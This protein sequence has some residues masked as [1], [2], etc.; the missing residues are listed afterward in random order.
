MAS[1]RDETF[2]AQ[3]DPSLRAVRGG[4]SNGRLRKVLVAEHD[5]WARSSRQQD[6]VRKTRRLV[7]ESGKQSEIAALLRPPWRTIFP[8]SG[9]AGLNDRGTWLSREL[10]GHAPALGPRRG[11]PQPQRSWTPLPVGL[12]GDGP[13][14]ANEPQTSNR[15]R[16]D[17][18]F[19]RFAARSR[20]PDRGGHPRPR[21]SALRRAMLALYSSS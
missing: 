15:G 7:P 14:V 6:A 17:G 2:S 1:G 5:L 11:G 19:E 8:A 9:L 16:L 4:V 18:D 21:S 10:G 3:A 12:L 20:C 13:A